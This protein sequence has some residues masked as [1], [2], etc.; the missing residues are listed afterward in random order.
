VEIAGDSFAYAG[1]LVLLF[2]APAAANASARTI[3][4]APT[5]TVPFHPQPLH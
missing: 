1:L 3:E 5:E 2:A 4:S